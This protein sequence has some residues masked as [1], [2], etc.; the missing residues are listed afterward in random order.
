M[1]SRN[2][3]RN[4]LPQVALFDAGALFTDFAS[5]RTSG[6]TPALNARLGTAR[7]LTEI[8]N[9]D[10][11]PCRFRTIFAAAEILRCRMP[12]GW[13]SMTTVTSA[14][15]RLLAQ[16]GRADISPIASKRRL[17]IYLLYVLP[18]QPS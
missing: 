12:A 15:S 3:Q 14:E 17:F 2:D 6:T 4:F 1:T 18:S 7:A 11:T 9:D 16:L 13:V 8:L 5:C 10:A